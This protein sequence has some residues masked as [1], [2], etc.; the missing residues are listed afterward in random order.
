MS[1][2]GSFN[3]VFSMPRRLVRLHKPV[4]QFPAT[5]FA[6]G[7]CHREN[8]TPNDPIGIIL[9]GAIGIHSTSSLVA[10]NDKFKAF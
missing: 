7:I 9:V 2:S 6:V 3:L 4:L 8:R 1:L 10:Y 5:M